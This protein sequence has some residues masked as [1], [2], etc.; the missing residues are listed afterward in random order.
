MRAAPLVLVSVI[1][2]GALGSCASGPC[3]PLAAPRPMAPPDDFGICTVASDGD[4][5]CSG[6]YG[7][8]NHLAVLPRCAQ[9]DPDCG[10]LL[11]YGQE[12]CFRTDAPRKATYHR[13]AAAR[14]LHHCAYDGEC[15][16][17][18]GMCWRYDVELRSSG[19]LVL[20]APPPDPT[21]DPW[22]KAFANPTWCGCVDGACDYFTY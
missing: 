17:R 14:E 19:P 20:E 13:A 10:P 2:L 9:G 6:S 21:K 11:V 12:T 8:G 22:G 16:V 4:P 3:R 15:G 5:V 1:L 7:L 18:L